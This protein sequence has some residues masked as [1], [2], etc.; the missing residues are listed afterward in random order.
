MKGV[1]EDSQLPLTVFCTLKMPGTTWATGEQQ[2]YLQSKL[3]K[4]SQH[5]DI[6]KVGDFLKSFCLQ[7]FLE[8]PEP[9]PTQGQITMLLR[10]KRKADE[11]EKKQ[12]GTGPA[13]LVLSHTVS[14]FIIDMTYV[15]VTLR[16]G[17]SYTEN[18]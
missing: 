10:K 8:F 7:W 17:H 5:Q 16:R 2:A 6:R 1:L 18:L 3:V 12:E 11:K 15:R 4:F 13:G 9:M 14:C